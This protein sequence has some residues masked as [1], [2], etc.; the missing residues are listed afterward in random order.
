MCQL[1]RGQGGHLGYRIHLKSINTWSG[2]NKEHLCQVW[3]RSLQP[4]L[5]RSSKCV[6]QSEAMVAIL[7]FRSLYK[8][9]TLGQDHV[10]NISGKLRKILF[11][12][13]REE[14]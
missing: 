12:S 7:D 9:T 3:S 10:R 4:F 8:V 5:R 1:I 13:F 6:S 14:V 2:P 11:N